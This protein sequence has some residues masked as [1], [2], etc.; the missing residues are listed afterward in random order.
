V[1]RLCFL[2]AAE[3]A[4][5]RNWYGTREERQIALHDSWDAA[6]ENMWW[7]CFE[8]CP[9]EPRGR[10]ELEG[11]VVDGIFEIEGGGKAGAGA[12][13]LDVSRGA[14]VVEIDLASRD[15]ALQLPPLAFPP[16]I[17]P[18]GRVFRRRRTCCV[19]ALDAALTAYCDVLDCRE[20]EP[21]KR[22]KP[23]AQAAAAAERRAA[24]AAAQ[25]SAAAEAA[26]KAAAAAAAAAEV[27]ASP[28]ASLSAMVVTAAAVVPTKDRVAEYKRAEAEASALSR[29]AVVGPAMGRA[30]AAG[31]GAAQVAIM[32]GFG[33][34]GLPLLKG[35]KVKRVSS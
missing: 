4:M 20:S 30:G 13:G 3:R 2:V 33:S 25:A 7:L 27:A 17:V 5:K 19:L 32:S 1:C 8:C 9:P 15:A 24:E 29:A 23:S 28:V 18:A 6:D 26:G 11:Y 31:V 12:G 21:P 16:P 22:P 35:T 10:A 34:D 14:G